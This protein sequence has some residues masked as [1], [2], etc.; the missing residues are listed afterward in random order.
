[1]EGPSPKPPRVRVTARQ[2]LA[3]DDLGLLLQQQQGRS[4]APRPRNLL[5]LRRRVAV[6]AITGLVLLV[7]ASGLAVALG[8]QLL[9]DHPPDWLLVGALAFVDMLLLAGWQQR[10]SHRLDDEIIGRQGW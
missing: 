2:T 10:A 7:L 8:A 5:I 1:M 4:R 6:R 9:F 3:A